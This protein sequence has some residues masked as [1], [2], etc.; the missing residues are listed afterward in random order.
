[1][2][3]LIVDDHASLARGLA[4]FLRQEG[5]TAALAA[6]V[7]EARRQLAGQDFDLIITDLKLPDGEG[8][9]VIRAARAAPSAPEVI[10]MTAFG[11]VESAVEAMKLGALDYLTKPVP[12]EEFAFRIDRVARLRRTAQRAET[13]ERARDTLLEAAGLA[14]PLAEIVGESPA[15]SAV[16]DLIRKAAGFPSTVLLTGETGTGKELAARAVHALSPWADGPFVRVNCASIPETLFEAELFGHEK[17]AFTDAR[18]RRIGRFEAARG[19]TLFLDEVGEVPLHLQA[20]LLRALQD[21]ELVRVGGTVPIK[22]DTRIVAATNRDLEAMA[23]AGTFRPDL[24][25]RL[26]VVRIALPPLRERREDVGLLAEHLLERLRQ[27]FGRPRL[28]FPPAALAALQAQPWPGN[29][30]ELKNAIERAVV[31][32]EGDEISIPLPPVGNSWGGESSPPGHDGPP[33]AGFPALATGAG[34]T[35]PGD[36][37]RAVGGTGGTHRHP[38]GQGGTSDITAV[39]PAGRTEGSSSQPFPETERGRPRPADEDG[40]AA[41][42]GLNAA[43]DALERRLILEALAQA[44]GV[45]ARAAALLRISRPNLVYRMK[46]HGLLDGPGES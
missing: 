27:E 26:A 44:G 8:L 10:L 15:I 41:G 17:G 28:R 25:Y 6:S 46:R 30:R 9:E 38:A 13:L 20:K 39:G 16:K 42:A 14:D 33:A 36:G 45:K 24:L 35:L 5:H 1:M 3:I 32:A 19:G 21:K 34:S 29:I 23:A 31:L 18:E 22:V 2:H 4:A 37:P 12:P 7:A 43:L 11:S 40:S